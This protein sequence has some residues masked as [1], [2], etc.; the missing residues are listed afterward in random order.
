MIFTDPSLNRRNLSIIPLMRLIFLLFFLP[1]LAIS[2]PREEASLHLESLQKVESQIKRLELASQSF[3]GLPY[4]KN[5]PLGEGETAR[6]DADPLYR[7]DTFDCTTFVETIVGLALS[8]N[9]DEFE[10][11]MNKI[12]YA[13]GE[14]GFLTRNH[15]TSLHWVPNNIQN[16]VFEEINDMVLPASEQKLARASI[17]VGGWLLKLST[18]AIQ[19]RELNQDEK[20]IRLQEL[21]D[22]APSYPP[23]EATLNYLPISTLLKNPKLLN[24]IPHGSIVNFVR[25]NWDLT[26]TAGTHLNVSH[27]GFLF[28]M[29]K[30]LYLRHA[31]TT[32]LVRNDVFLEYLKKFQNHATMKGIHLL[33]LK[34]LR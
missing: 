26:E 19:G 6:Y 8:S 21:R 16:G 34:P 17:D 32:G 5:G 7:F 1:A 31:S 10:F 28:R 11:N 12:R 20:E 18:A 2:S 27:Q 4:G 30:T 33:R 9:V 15:Y 3:V 22:L 23:V 29:G 14:V 25:P 13:H 24:R